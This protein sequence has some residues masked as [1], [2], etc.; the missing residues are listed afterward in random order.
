MAKISDTAKYPIT[1]PTTSDYFLGT[2]NSDNKKTVS[3]TIDA[4]KNLIAQGIDA[5]LLYMSPSISDLAAYSGDLNTAIVTGDSSNFAISSIA[6]SSNTSTITFSD[7]RDLSEIMEDNFLFVYGCPNE[8]NN[9]S[10]LIKSV[11]NNLKTISVTN[12]NGVSQ[13]TAGGKANA[14]RFRDGL[15]TFASGNLEGDGGTSITS[16]GRDGRWERVIG[17]SD[18]IRLDWWNL[19]VPDHTSIFQAAFNYANADWN[20]GDPQNSRTVYIPNVASTTTS[21]RYNLSNN[22]PIIIFCNVI[23][24]ADA[25]IVYLPDLGSGIDAK[26]ASCFQIGVDQMDMESNILAY[27]SLSGFATWGS[28]TSIAADTDAAYG[29]I[30]IEMNSDL[31]TPLLG[32]GD[33]IQVRR[34]ESAYNNA[35]FEIETIDSTNNYIYGYYSKYNTTVPSVSQAVADTSSDIQARFRRAS[36]EDSAQTANGYSIVLPQIF[37]GSNA[38]YTL[39]RNTDYPLFSNRKNTAVVL[40]QMRSCIVTFNRIWYFQTA[41]RILG[42]DSISAIENNLG[43]IYYLG[44]FKDN[45]IHIDASPNLNVGKGNTG[46]SGTSKGGTCNNN[47]FMGGYINST[48]Y[49]SVSYPASG[50]NLTSIT[51]NG[52]NVTATFAVGIPTTDDLQVGY[53]IQ[54][55]NNNSS[56]NDGVF[57]ITAKSGLSVTYVNP[58][59]VVDASPIGQA[60]VLYSDLPNNHLLRS[61]SNT[62]RVVGRPDNNNFIGTIFEDR[63]AICATQFELVGMRKTCFIGCRYETGDSDYPD[64]KNKPKMNFVAADGNIFQNG[65]GL[66]N[67][68]VTTSE[69]SA[70]NKFFS[71]RDYDIDVS[72]A[73]SF[74]VIEYGE[75]KVS[76]GLLSVQNVGVRFPTLEDEYAEDNTVYYSSTASKLVYKDGTGTVNNLY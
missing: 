30:R 62:S 67:R 36:V 71:E 69:N 72:D 32:V 6:F 3:F 41:I 16:T 27:A 31:Y 54:L 24:D 39:S 11:N 61:F 37:C 56:G 47:I 28:V 8:N 70:G 68:V 73:S 76:G 22:S 4:V 12:V 66:E 20:A 48:Q 53:M 42:S 38:T 75:M 44:R 14:P 55:R 33:F 23:S 25:R 26:Y 40:K 35:S 29:R 52:D 50:S 19:N 10:F 64:S 9:G 45:G 18:Y 46:Q 58:S 57:T 34:S 59:G 7:N 2:D 65:T 1:T 43:N 21:L 13:E 63:G 49:L 51:K 5:S 15:F 60:R 17:R 74:R